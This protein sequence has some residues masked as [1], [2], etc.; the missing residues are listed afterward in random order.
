MVS[1]DFGLLLGPEGFG[2]VENMINKE[3]KI[4][5]QKYNCGI[6]FLHWLLSTE[7]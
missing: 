5:I 1:C 6:F 4:T 2:V 7:I 3:K